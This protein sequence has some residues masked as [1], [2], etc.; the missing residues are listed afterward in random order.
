MFGTGMKGPGWQDIEV[1]NDCNGKPEI[2]LYGQAEKIACN[3]GITR[4]HISL[5]HEKE[6]AVAYVIGEGR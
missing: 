6:Y 4:I 2:Q 5:S 1:V 3:K